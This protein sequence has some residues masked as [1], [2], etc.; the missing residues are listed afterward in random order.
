MTTFEH[1]AWGLESGLVIGIILIGLLN[2]WFAAEA[3]A[4]NLID[5]FEVERQKKDKEYHELNGRYRDTM[6]ELEAAQ[7]EYDAL[8]AYI[9]SSIIEA[10]KMIGIDRES[11]DE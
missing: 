4:S 5:R 2:V 10:T 1:V 9:T 3:K 6:K 11:D 7:G 8:K